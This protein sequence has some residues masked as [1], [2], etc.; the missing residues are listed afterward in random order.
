MKKLVFLLLAVLSLFSCEDKQV[1][2]VAFQAKVDDRL[3]ISTDARAAINEDGSVTIQGFTGDEALTL[4]ISNLA[5][6]NFAIG[7][8]FTNYAVYEDFEGN[9]YTTNPNGE[10]QITISELNE[11][12][13]TLSGNF[14]F[15]AFLPGIDTIYVSKGTL[16]NV[17]YSGGDIPDPTNAGTFSAKVD[18]N[19][20][21]PVTVT[22]RS[23]SNTIMISGS[24]SNST[25]VVSVPPGIVVGEYMFPGGNVRLK[26]QDANGPETTSEGIVNI[27]E[28]NTTAKTIKGTFSFLTN[29]TEITEGQ[30][31]VAY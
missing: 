29:R 8:G 9:V 7:E 16:F 19:P 31:D 22:A 28:H 2:E 3:Y 24:T 23:T 13:K 27:I 4:R 11:N 5:K 18:G 20:F 30:F 21:I 25:I 15:N 10:G 6:G 14:D 12:D 17:S 26:Y 1:N